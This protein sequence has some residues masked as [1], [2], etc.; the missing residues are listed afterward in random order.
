V[1]QRVQKE[2]DAQ[3]DGLEDL[4][5]DLSVGAAGWSLQH[6]VGVRCDHDQ[7][8]IEDVILSTAC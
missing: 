3:G 6:L 7:H 5:I 2:C 1:L 8:L 4:G